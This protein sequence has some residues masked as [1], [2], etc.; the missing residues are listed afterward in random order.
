MDTILVVEDEINVRENVVELLTNEGFNC[1]EAEDGL[2]GTKIIKQ[3]LPDLILCDLMMPKI[4]G[5]EFYQIVRSMTNEQFIP[6]IFLTARTDKESLQYAMGLG[7]DD[8]ITKPF[9]A[10][11]LLERINIRLLKKKSVEQNFD[12]LKMNISLYVP[13]ELNTPLVSILGYTELLLLDFEEFS[14]IEKKELISTVHQSGLRLENR[15]AK[16]MNFSELKLNTLE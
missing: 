9:K 10:D 6:F 12:Q 11:E 13:H 5:F 8:F 15:I 14:D 2:S 7:A 3:E 16:F 4:D 1:I